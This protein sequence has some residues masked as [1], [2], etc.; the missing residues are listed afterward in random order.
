MTDKFDERVKEIVKNDIYERSLLPPRIIK[1]NIELNPSLKTLKH[2]SDLN[3]FMM[4]VEGLL[5]KVGT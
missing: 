2:L 5:K 1:K 3:T 4:I